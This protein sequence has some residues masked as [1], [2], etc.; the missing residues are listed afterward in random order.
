MQSRILRPGYELPER[1]RAMEAMAFIQM[2]GGFT[3]NLLGETNRFLIH[4][5]HAESWVDAVKNLAEDD[6]T[7]VLW[8]FA[9]PHLELSV[10]KPYSVR[11]LF[12]FAAV[13]LLHQANAFKKQDWKDDLASDRDIDYKLL[14]KLGTGWNTFPQFLVAINQLND[15]KFIQATGNFR[16]KGQHRYRLNFERGLT[17]VV[18]RTKGRKGITYS[19]GFILPLEPSKLVANLY[20]QHQRARDVFLAYWK[21]LNELCDACDNK[22]AKS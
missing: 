21:L 15:E 7:S 16:H 6:R 4:V 5:H 12:I 2:A 3:R 19:F 13:H 14:E 8:E 11:N 9:E 10:G 22:C 17:L 1:V 20:E 18:E